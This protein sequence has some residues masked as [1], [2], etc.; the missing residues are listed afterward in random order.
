MVFKTLET[1]ELPDIQSVG[2]IYEHEET[3]AR[4]LHLKNDDSNKAF[5]IGFKTPPYNDNGI[6]HIL[7][8]FENNRL[9][10]PRAEYI[11]PKHAKY[12]PLEERA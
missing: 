3:G 8:Q 9:I 4:V 11:G 12:V 2:T 5:T 6:A 7:E 1:Q 10:R